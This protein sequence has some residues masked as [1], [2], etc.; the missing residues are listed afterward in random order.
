MRHLHDICLHN[1]DNHVYMRDRQ[2]ATELHTPLVYFRTKSYSCNASAQ[3]V[4]TQTPFVVQQ[5]VQQIHNISTCRDVLDLLW[6]GFVVDFC[7]AANH[8]VPCNHVDN[9]VIICVITILFTT[10]SELILQL[11]IAR[12]LRR[13]IMSQCC[14]SVI[15]ASE[16]DREL[17]WARQSFDQKGR[18]LTPELPRAGVGVLVRGCKYPPWKFRNLVKL[19][20]PR[21]TTEMTKC[22]ISHRN[23]RYTLKSLQLIS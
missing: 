18:S 6:S 7:V 23:T 13:I 5:A 20:I 21:K 4:K 22:N 16:E 8:S 9:Y 17:A 3:R 11:T 12:W 14:G 19:L 1:R 15:N 10:A 2:S